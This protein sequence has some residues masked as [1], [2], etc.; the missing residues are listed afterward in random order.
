M[1]GCGVR[2]ARL[3]VGFDWASG[4][5]KEGVIGSRME[6]RD[7]VVSDLGGRASISLPRSTQRG[8]VNPS[9]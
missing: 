4:G 3:L 9:F 6:Y 2:R 1:Y 7:F 8:K 5:L